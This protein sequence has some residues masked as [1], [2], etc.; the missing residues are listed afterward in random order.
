MEEGRPLYIQRLDV[1]AFIQL[2]SGINGIALLK[3][4]RFSN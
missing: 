4:T 2:L 3:L 1:C